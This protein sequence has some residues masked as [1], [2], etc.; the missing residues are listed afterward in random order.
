MYRQWE[1]LAD[2]VAMT[3][4][5]TYTLDLL[6][7]TGYLAGLWLEFS[8]AQVSPLGLAGG[9]WRIIDYLTNIE[10]RLNQN[11]T[12]F[13]LNGRLAQAV[14]GYRL[15]QLPYGNWRNY[16][17]NTQREIIPILFGT[18]PWDTRRYLDLS[19]MNA[20]Q[21][22]I[23]NNATSSQFTDISVTVYALWLRD[24]Q[25]ATQGYVRRELY[26]EYAP[27]AG[28]TDAQYLPVEFPLL[29]VYVQGDPGL[30]A[31]GRVNTSPQNLLYN[32]RFALKSRQID[33][34]NDQIAH[35]MHYSPVLFDYLGL[36]GGI[37]YLNNGKE[38]DVGIAHVDQFLISAG[39]KLATAA[40]VIPTTEGDENNPTQN[41]YGFQADTLNAFLARGKGFHNL[42]PLWMD[43][44]PDLSELIDPKANEQVTVDILTR[45]TATVTSAQI[46][47]VLERLVANYP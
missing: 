23:A 36:S 15:G 46:R 41:Q 34:Y 44:T 45:S 31:N 29:G 6:Q 33:L 37:N 3:L 21:L 18:S 13:A 17:S 30:D 9:N 25:A 16:A 32:V 20:V 26:R 35:L 1:K 22:R 4:N 28:S 42:I 2:G 24:V 14:A 27:T 47:T 39:T 12:G 11:P 10:V 38:H 5:S 19:R 7:R 43:K 40:T 8:G